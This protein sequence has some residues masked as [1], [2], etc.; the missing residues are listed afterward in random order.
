MNPA[1]WDERALAARTRM[2]KRIYFIDCTVSEGD[3]CVGHQL[4][5]N[6]R[7]EMIERLDAIGVGEITM[8]SHATFS[9]ERDLIQACRR[10]GYEIEPVRNAKGL[11]EGFEI[12]GVS[13][14]IRQRFSKRR[15]EVEAAI[16]QFVAERGRQPNPAEIA[17]LASETRSAKL[18]EI[19]TP[20]VRQLQRS[21]QP[22]S[23]GNPRRS[24]ECWPKYPLG[25]FSPRPG[26]PESRAKPRPPGKASPPNTKDDCANA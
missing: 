25:F 10:L 18:K 22:H 5:W 7:L 12:K 11:V 20:Q 26:G 24:W 17:Q 4:N 13:E 1:Y 8:P 16:N 14:E 19:T 3:D 21:E 9:E 15:A 23:T 6:T 2:P